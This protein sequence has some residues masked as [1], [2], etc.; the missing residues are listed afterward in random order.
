MGVEGSDNTEV[1]IGTAH[2]FLV[3]EDGE[4]HWL[5]V[6]THGLGGGIFVTKDAALNYARRETDKRPGAVTLARWPVMFMFYSQK[7]AA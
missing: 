1:P 6:E 7:R 4:G 5:A 2:T 3:G